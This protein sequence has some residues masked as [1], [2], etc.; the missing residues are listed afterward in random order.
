MTRKMTRAG[1][2]KVASKSLFFGARTGVKM[3]AAKKKA[4]NK[5]VSAKMA[6]K[7]ATPKQKYLAKRWV[8]K[9]AV[10]RKAASKR[11]AKNAATYILSAPRG[12]RVLTHRE[13]K[14]AVERVFE[15]RY[16]IDA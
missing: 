5:A 7:K 16:G 12:A 14:Q 13:I 4:L 6:V 9:S 10:S 1:A 2:R 11:V 3:S 8:A 15:E